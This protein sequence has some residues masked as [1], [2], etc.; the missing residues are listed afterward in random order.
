M[1]ISHVVLWVGSIG[2]AP[3]N[4]PLVLD[5]HGDGVKDSKGKFIPDGIQLRPFHEQSWYYNNSSHALRI[6]QTP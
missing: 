5:S 2:K 6:L 3:D 4:V 1:K